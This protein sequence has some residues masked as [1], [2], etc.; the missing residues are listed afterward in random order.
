MI[1]QHTTRWL[2]LPVRDFELGKP[3]TEPEWKGIL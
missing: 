1:N 2:E 3:I